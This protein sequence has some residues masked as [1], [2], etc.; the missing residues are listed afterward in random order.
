MYLLHLKQFWLVEEWKL[1][2]STQHWILFKIDDL[3]KT[4]STEHPHIGG[5]HK[6][7]IGGLI[8]YYE[9][10]RRHFKP[11]QKKLHYHTPI[12]FRTGFRFLKKMKCWFW[13]A[14]YVN[15]HNLK[16][17]QLW[18]WDVKP[19]RH[20]DNWPQVWGKQIKQV[21]CN[22][23]KI[24]FLSWL[25]TFTLLMLTHKPLLWRYQPCIKEWHLTMKANSYFCKKM[26]FLHASN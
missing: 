20:K 14:V 22:K 9:I 16:T 12:A 11:L 10:Y 23:F 2:T 13:F 6:R 15:L 21:F 17:N 4:Q 25:P 26:V 7:D 8:L 19:A 24:F 5:N 3:L 1:F 18:S